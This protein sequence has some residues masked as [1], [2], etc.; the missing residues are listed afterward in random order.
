MRGKR[1]VSCISAARR[2]IT[3]AHA[4]KTYEISLETGG[5][6]DHPRACGENISAARRTAKRQ[7]SPPRMRGKLR[8]EGIEQL[9]ERITPAH[10][11][12]TNTLICCSLPGKDHP[13]ACGENSVIIQRCRLCQRITPAH[14][15]KT[16]GVCGY[17]LYRQD[18]P[19]ACG[20]NDTTILWT[21]KEIGSPPRMRGKLI[22]SVCAI[23][24]LRITPA[25]AGKTARSVLTADRQ[26]D[27]PRACGENRKQPPR[28][29]SQ[30]GSPPRMRGKQKASA[31]D[32]MPVGITPAH[33]G[34]TSRA[35]AR[36]RFAEDHPR[37]CGENRGEE[38]LC[39]L[40]TGSP[41]RMRGKLQSK[42]KGRMTHGITPAHAGKTCICV[43]ARFRPRDH[44]RACG[45]NVRRH[46]KPEKKRGSPPRMRGKLECGHYDAHTLGITPAHAGKTRF[47]SA[48]YV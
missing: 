45:E 12:K 6:R 10:A 19:R 23:C 37:A 8:Y 3:P 36:Q 18:H 25:H 16:R 44:P 38:K 11:G 35:A 30:R 42:S 24:R 14:A 34:K 15:G 40:G 20:E 5:I 41:P 48:S 2:R 7:G 26:Q 13:R 21:V 17:L 43:S 33:A 22:K 32:Y 4:G 47:V 9:L 1:M 46:I 31:L 27:H 29:F 39:K 28:N